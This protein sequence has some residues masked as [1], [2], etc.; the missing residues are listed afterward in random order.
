MKIIKNKSN[1]M[2]RNISFEDQFQIMDTLSYSAYKV[3]LYIVT[4]EE[5]EFF[6]GR[7]ECAKYFDKNVYYRGLEELIKN[8]YLIKINEEEYIL[9][10]VCCNKTQKC[11]WLVYLHTFPDGKKYVG[12]TSKTAEERWGR[13]GRNYRN[14]Y[15]YEGIQLWG[16]DNIKHEILEQGLTE[17]A[18]RVREQYY[19]KQLNSYIE[20]NGYNV[21][22]QRRERG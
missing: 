2:Y 21:A 22:A 3:W 4:R 6:I 5:E 11:D 14:M 7:K 12:I 10:S 20:T 8:N 9:N 1:G 13:E 17:S 16:W 18:A 15:V 19:I